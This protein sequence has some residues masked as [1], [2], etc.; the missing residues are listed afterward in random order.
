MYLRNTNRKVQELVELKARMGGD[1]FRTR[2][3]SR[4]LLGQLI[5]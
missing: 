4:T 2:N 5:N 1:S 3:S